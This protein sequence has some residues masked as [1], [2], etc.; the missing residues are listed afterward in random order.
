MDLQRI[1]L[2]ASALDKLGSAG[3]K[4]KKRLENVVKDLSI[5]AVRAF[6]SKVPIDTGELRNQNIDVKIEGKGL[7]TTAIIYIDDAAEHYGRR[8]ESMLSVVLAKALQAGVYK[9]KKLNRTRDSAA[10]P[11]YSSIG[12]RT[13]TAGW[14][15][16]GRAAFLSS[17][18]TYLR[19]I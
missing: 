8:K 19:N 5:T 11:P 2:D 6:Q 10:F 16:K 9:G 7:N 1:Q 17:Y 18:K 13:T 3:I 12:A 15:Y 14:I 4:T